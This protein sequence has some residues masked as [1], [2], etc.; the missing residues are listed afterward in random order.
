M[1]SH[2]YTANSTV[3]QTL[4]QAPGIHQRQDRPS[5]P[6]EADVLGEK[7]GTKGDAL[8]F[9]REAEPVGYI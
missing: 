1:E 2:F 9:S 3:C 8:E 5:L 4:C 7:M 6:Q